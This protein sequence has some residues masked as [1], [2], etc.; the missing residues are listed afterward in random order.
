MAHSS[1]YQEF[2]GPDHPDYEEDN[3]V[4]QMEYEADLWVR[5]HQ[6]HKCDGKLIWEW[7]YDSIIIFCKDCGLAAREVP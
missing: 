1:T 3:W 4:S 2:H 5:K 7:D 6:C